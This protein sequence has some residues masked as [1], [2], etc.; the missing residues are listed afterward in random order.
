LCCVQANWGILATVLKRLAIDL[1]EREYRNSI[2]SNGLRAKCSQKLA[3]AP[4]AL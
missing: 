1:G 2:Y 4:I 3:P